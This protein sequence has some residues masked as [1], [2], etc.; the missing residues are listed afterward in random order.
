MRV[1]ALAVVALACV[2]GAADVLHPWKADFSPPS[3]VT[4]PKF[5]FVPMHSDISDLDYKAIQDNRAHLLATLGWDYPE[6]YSIEN[7]KEDLQEY[8]DQFGNRSAYAFSI[9]TPDKK[10][11]IGAFFINRPDFAEAGEPVPEEANKE[12]VAGARSIEASM[13]LDKAS[14]DA[15]VDKELLDAVTDWLHASW[16][17]DAMMLT[18]NAN[19]TKLLKLVVEKGLE[20]H[21]QEA[22]QDTVYV[23]KKPGFSV[24]LASL[25][26]V[27]HP[28]DEEGDE[29]EEGDD[30]D[31]ADTEELEG[32]EG[33]DG[34]HEEGEDHEEG[35]EHEEG[36][37][38]EE[39]ADEEAKAEDL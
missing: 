4:H 1:A 30:G 38:P 37:E 18:T 21:V 24:D 39:L 3:G 14:T 11:A 33:S 22:Y 36:D 27:E 12:W 29:D 2:V 5:V 8:S 31:D 23:W 20:P 17:V 6:D 26:E 13:W 9:Q 28:A 19:N 15:G 16:P 34:E 7:N 10:K 25:K 35:E 32:E